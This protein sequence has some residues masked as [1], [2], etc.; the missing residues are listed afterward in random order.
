MALESTRNYKKWYFLIPLLIFIIIL[1]LVS[2]GYTQS[3]DEAITSYF[4]SIRTPIVTK[5]MEVLSF[6]G[7]TPTYVVITIII[8]F[9]ELKEGL[10][11]GGHLLITQLINRVIKFIIKRPRPDKINWLVQESNYSFPSGHAMSAM[12]GYGLLYIK[13]KNSNFKY[14]NI[15][16]IISIAMVFLIS[17][18]R[19]YLG[20]HYFSDVLAGMIL[21]LSYIL[22]VTNNTSYY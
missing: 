6:L 9:I 12:C 1:I 20:V 2:N 19:I 4:V 18:S 15:L 17:I 3:L 13:F 16:C 11:Y 7:S 10:F 22:F 21:A 5:I 14:K 8:M